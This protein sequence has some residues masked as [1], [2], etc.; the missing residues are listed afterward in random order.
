MKINHIALYFV[1]AILLMSCN[2]DFDLIEEGNEQPIVYGFINVGVDTQFVRVEKTFAGEDINAFNGAQNEDSIYYQDAIVSLRDQESGEVFLLEKVDAS[3]LGYEREAGDFL[4]NPNIAYSIPTVDLGWTGGEEITLELQLEEN[5]PPVTAETVV[6]SP[7]LLRNPTV[8]N[9]TNFTFNK[10]R[11]EIRVKEE[12][13]IIGLT[14]YM[15]IRETNMV[16]PSQVELIEIPWVL[17]SGF[18][19]DK[20]SEFQFPSVEGR[21]FYT[22]IAENLDKN[23]GVFRQFSHFDLVIEGGGNEIIEYRRIQRANSGLTGSQELPLYSNIDG[24]I[25]IFSSKYSQRIE[26][27]LVQP[28]TRDSLANGSITGDFNFVN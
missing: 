2:N 7:V 13:G 19:V 12:V 27:F 11:F 5:E 1:A 22:T 16:D 14:M 23:K 18:E 26:D 28:A 8:D 20:T 3:L 10:K 6:L 4:Q 9:P 21:L 15:Y 25:G 17:V 24:G